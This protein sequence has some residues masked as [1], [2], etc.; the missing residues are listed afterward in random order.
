MFLKPILVQVS[1]MN[2]SLPVLPGL[3]FCTSVKIRILFTI[4]L[5]TLASCG[6]SGSDGGGDSIPVDP[7]N[8]PLVGSWITP[9]DGSSGALSLMDSLE[10]FT[11]GTF[12]RNAS[13]YFD[14]ACTAPAFDAATTGTVRE[15]N[16]FELPDRGIVRNVDFITNTYAIIP[17]S[18]ESVTFFN[19]Q[20]TCGISDWEVGVTVDISSCS[21]RPGDDTSRRPTPYA[22]YSIYLVERGQL[23]YGNEISFTPENRPITLATRPS[24]IRPTGA[25]GDEFPQAL[26]GFWL[27]P[28][29]NQYLELADQGLINFYGQTEQGCFVSSFLTLFSNGGNQYQDPFKFYTYTISESDGNLLLSAGTD[30]QVFVYVPAEFPVD[31]LDQCTLNQP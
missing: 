28:E 31:Q 5:C 27:L 30:P 24:Y 29:S 6:G 17:R 18:E 1:G 19:S 20:S 2:S 26:K 10:F 9:C 8:S 3:A 11:D 23:F 7:A 16:A 15:S 25:I 14:L 12:V 13:G 22:D 4:S 21:N